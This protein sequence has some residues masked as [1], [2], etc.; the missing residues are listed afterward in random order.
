MSST[1]LDSRQ[2]VQVIVIG[3]LSAAVAL[4]VM[5][6]AWNADRE[7]RKGVTQ[8]RQRAALQR[9]CDLAAANARANMSWLAPTHPQ[10]NIALHLLTRD[11]AWAPLCAKDGAAGARLQN[12]ILDAAAPSPDDIRPLAQQ[13]VE[14]L[15]ER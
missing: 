15:E 12:D 1:R 6:N 4:A 10:R 5:I 2:R 3:V 11:A 9:A 7:H 8:L 13:L 14:L